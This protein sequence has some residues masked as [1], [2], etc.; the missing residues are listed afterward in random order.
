MNPEQ[1]GQLIGQL[2][3]ALLF[4]LAPLVAFRRA[5]RAEPRSRRLGGYALGCGLLFLPLLALLAVTRGAGGRGLFVAVGVALVAAGVL[6]VALAVAS[7]SA[8]REDGG[9]GAA[10][11]WAIGFGVLCLV[12]GPGAA[13]FPFLA[14][15]RTGTPDAPS[16]TAWAYKIAP[17]G[18]EVGLPSDRWK[19]YDHPRDVAMFASRQPQMVSSVKEVRPAATDAEFGRVVADL[20]RLAANNPVTVIEEKRE[21]NAHGHEHWRF[22][23]EEKTDKGRVMVAMSVTWWNKTHAV[24]VLFEGQYKALSQV[25]QDQEA[26]GFASAARYVLASVK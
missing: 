18:F 1:T 14:N 22:L 2:V 24:V 3:G 20:K 9:G 5:A 15:P 6:A 10:A 8:R 16:G 7:R 23:G 13:V 26:E 19:K 21:P 4:A 17:P 25:G 12:L 11:L